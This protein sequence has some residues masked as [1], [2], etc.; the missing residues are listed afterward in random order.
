MADWV[1]LLGFADTRNGP[2]LAQAMQRAMQKVPG[3]AMRLIEAGGLAALAQDQSA[4]LAFGLGSLGSLGSL[5]GLGGPA[6]ALRRLRTVQQRL[7]VACVLGPFLPA[8]PAHAR[9]GRA[10]IPALL[11]AGAPALHDALA[12]PGTRHQW[13]VVLCWQP[14]DVVA[15]RRSE[16][17]AAATDAGGS[18]E[19]LAAAV[20]GA[21]ARERTRRE[22]ALRQA[23]A[24]HALAMAPTGAGAT[25]TG[26]TV[27]L[28]AAGEAGL[29]AALNALPAEVSAGA[30]IALRGPLP[31][32]SFA[33]VRIDRAAASDVAQA[34]CTL[35][36][37]DQVD[38]AALRRHWR[39]CAA[40]LH[41]DRG[42]S[43]GPM[44]SAGAAFRLLRDLLPDEDGQRPWSLP[45]LQRHAA[46]RMSVHAPVESVT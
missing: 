9:C 10:A 7:E 39:D 1:T 13:D 38:A 8:D 44:V 42:G 43:D 29:E 35:A 6:A 11:A 4:R 45:A 36:L 31:P 33:A 40:R 17:A 5:G 15:S 18:R 16:I 26:L 3:P 30:S 14:N 24:P 46:C 23:V 21:L 2:A 37:P 19:A 25:E 34:W 22:A 32:V 20:Q 41:P 27:L 28:P 12:G